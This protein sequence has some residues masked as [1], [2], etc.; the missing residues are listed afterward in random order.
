MLP[1]SSEGST[2]CEQMFQV[3]PFVGLS[4]LLARYLNEI[5]SQFFPCLFEYL[6]SP[7]KKLCCFHT[8]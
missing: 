5:P 4:P 2:L 3:H 7:P 1:A 6:E 8:R